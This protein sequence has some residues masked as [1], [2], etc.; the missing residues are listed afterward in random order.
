[1]NMT[2]YKKIYF[3]FFICC[4]DP[5]KENTDVYFC[6]ESELVERVSNATSGTIEK[7]VEKNLP[8][9]ISCI[10]IERMRDYIRLQGDKT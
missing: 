10:P 7:I 8:K 1:M 5:S 9:I 2:F 3:L 6:P 4:Y